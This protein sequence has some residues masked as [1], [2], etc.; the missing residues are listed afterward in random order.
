MA[1]LDI[2]PNLILVRLKL[3]WNE[4]LISHTEKKKTMG[5]V[6]GEH[7]DKVDKV[8]VANAFTYYNLRVISVTNPKIV[9]SL[10]APSPDD[11]YH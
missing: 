11:F 2:I 8:K 10:N 3:I 9:I 4:C 7:W 6:F 1:R 5:P